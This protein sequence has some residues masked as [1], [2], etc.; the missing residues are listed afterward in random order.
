MICAVPRRN[1]AMWCCM[2]NSSTGNMPF[3]TR[4]SDDFMRTGTQAGIGWALSD[5]IE[6]AV[7]GD[8]Y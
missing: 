2:L 1:S 3:Y 6:H 4:P 8:D 7:L 5:S